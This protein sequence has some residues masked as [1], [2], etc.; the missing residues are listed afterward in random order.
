MS[1]EEFTR[2]RVYLEKTQRQMAALLGVSIKAVQSFEQGWRNIPP[3]AERQS[4]FLLAAAAGAP[5]DGRKCWKVRKCSGAMK[6]SCPAFELRHG[7]RCWFVNGSYCRGKDYGGWP[8][9]MSE[10]RKCPVFL[11]EMP[12]GVLLPLP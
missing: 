6:G 4:L 9:K 10:C 5:D 2:I 11:S 12:S 7:Q 1:P 8:R 3:H